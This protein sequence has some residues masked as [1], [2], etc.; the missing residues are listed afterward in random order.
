[1]EF[2][3]LTGLSGAGKTRAMHAMEDIGFFCVDNLPPALIPVFYDLCLKTEGTQ[4]RAAVVTDTRG[5]ELF[6]SFFT[7][8]ESLKRDKKPYKI[9]FLD[10][11]DSVLVNR[12]QETRRKHPSPTRWAALWSRPSSWSG[13]C[14]SPSKSARTMS[15]TPPACPRPS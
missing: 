7:A 8:L 11:S 10:S 2:V 3:I 13:R 5:G 9:L 1:M 6:K 12:F 14:S 15:S 4:N